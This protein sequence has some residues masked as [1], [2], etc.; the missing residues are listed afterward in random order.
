MAVA[1]PFPSFTTPTC[2]S[3]AGSRAWISSMPVSARSARDASADVV[4]PA[5]LLVPLA[6]FDRRG[7]RIG[8]GKGHYDRVIERLLA[9]GEPLMTIGLAFSLQEVDEVPAETHDRPLDLIVT[10]LGLKLD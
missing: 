6:A 1:S 7:N 2:S 3:A 10:E 4:R 9:D 8:W 5:I